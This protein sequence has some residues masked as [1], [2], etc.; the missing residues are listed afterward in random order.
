MRGASKVT[1]QTHQVLRLQRNSE[2]KISARNPWIASAAKKKEADSTTFRAWSQRDPSMIWPWHRHLAPAASAT[3]LVRSWRRF[4]IEKYNMSRS[5]YLPKCH[6]MPRLPQKSHSNFTTCC[7]CHAKWIACVILFT[8]ETSFPMRA[9][10][11][12]T[13]QLHQILCL[14]GKMSLMSDPRTYMNHYFQCAE[15]VESP[16]KLT[17][18]CACHEILS[19]TFQLE[20]LE[21]LRQ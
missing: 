15:Q 7:A 2:L 17:K 11:K 5:G 9:A 8:Y 3:L 10:T 14:P 18:Y 20:I 6:Q 21:L 13:F 19:S 4:C 16:F 1:F 12:V